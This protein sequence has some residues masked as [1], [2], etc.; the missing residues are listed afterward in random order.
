M[1]P[2]TKHIISLYQFSLYLTKFKI[3]NIDIYIYVFK[4]IFSKNIFY[5]W[6]GG[7]FFM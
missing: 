1:T 6:S 2:Q 5:N 7:T 4:Y 3:N